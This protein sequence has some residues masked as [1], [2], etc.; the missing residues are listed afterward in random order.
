MRL[1]PVR[2]FPLWTELVHPHKKIF[3][4]DDAFSVGLAIPES[5]DPERNVGKKKVIEPALEKESGWLCQVA[6]HSYLIY[7]EGTLLEEVNVLFGPP[8]QTMTVNSWPL[9]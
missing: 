3:K 4:P 1:C 2:G 6:L 7:A 5:L 8:F 9:V